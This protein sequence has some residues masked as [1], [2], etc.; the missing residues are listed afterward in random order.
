MQGRKIYQLLEL[1]TEEDQERFSLFLESPYH[2]SSKTLTLFWKQW[3]KKVIHSEGGE[4]LSI[5]GFVKGSSLKASRFDKL[6]SQLYVKAKEFL[7]L[8]SFEEKKVIQEILF[9]SAVLGRDQELDTAMGLAK[10]TSSYLEKQLESP[11]KYIAQMYHALEIASAQINARKPAKEFL[12]DFAKMLDLL[13]NFYDSRGMSHS[14][15]ALNIARIIQQEDTSIRE[16]LVARINIENRDEPKSLLAKLYYL[17]LRLQLEFAASD[18]LAQ[19]LP[20]L[21]SNWQKIEEDVVND[22]YNFT[23]NYCIR[24]A[25]GGNYIFLEYTFDLYNQLLKNE[26]LLHNG[27]LYP[28]QYKNIV[29]TGCRVNRLE[30]VESFTKEFSERLLDD[31]D[32]W[33]RIYNEGIFRFYQ[34]SYREAIE[35]FKDVIEKGQHDIFYGMDA[36]MYLWKAYFEHLNHLAPDEIDEMYKLYDSVRLYIDRHKKISVKHKLQYRNFVRLFKRFMFLLLDQ[37]VG[38]NAEDLLTFQTE[39]KES[40]DVANQAWFTQKVEETIAAM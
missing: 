32:G 20:I 11:E 14:V 37:G 19:L 3:L 2:N 18:A 29:G 7:T 39:L 40:E 25:N 38:R 35:I 27:K 15:A 30:W 36:R 10:K 31:H 21:E 12:A 23:L 13:D 5:D 24:Q 17:I 34:G 22:I 8:R 1:L 9:S 26:L 6:C 28:Q 16:R 4:D 33:A